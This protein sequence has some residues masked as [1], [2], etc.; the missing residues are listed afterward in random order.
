MLDRERRQKIEWNDQIIIIIMWATLSWFC[1]NMLGCILRPKGLNSWCLGTTLSSN[2]QHPSFLLLTTVWRRSA[3]HWNY[4]RKSYKWKQS[5][6]TQLRH[7]NTQDET[8]AISVPTNI[9][10]V[11]G[12]SCVLEHPVT[13]DCHYI[14]QTKLQSCAISSCAYNSIHSYKLFVVHL[15]ATGCIL[16]IRALSLPTAV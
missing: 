3:E 6:Q 10:F 15:L 9:V 13:F 11:S 16:T 4:V 5:A 12:F 2:P 14:V 7:N 8:L 1:K